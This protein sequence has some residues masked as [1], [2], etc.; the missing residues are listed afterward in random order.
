MQM[1]LQKRGNEGELL[2]QGR[3]DSTT[4]PDAEQ[5]FRELAPRFDHITLNLAGLEYISSAGL[6]VI[7]QLHIIM[8]KKDGKLTI[9][10]TPR[11]V[12]EVFEMTGFAGL[13][14]FV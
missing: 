4:S 3:L 6:R 2:L 1:T 5:L 14:E 11:I 13:F 9:R 12:M 10:N 8:Q 7:K